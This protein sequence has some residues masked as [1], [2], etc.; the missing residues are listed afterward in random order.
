MPRMESLSPKLDS[1]LDS[2]DLMGCTTLLSDPLPPAPSFSGLNEACYDGAEAN[3][4][5]LCNCKYQNKVTCGCKFINKVRIASHRATHSIQITSASFAYFFYAWRSLRVRRWF[6]DSAWKWK[7]RG[8]P[9]A[10]WESTTR[11]NDRSFEAIVK[12]RA[13]RRVVFVSMSMFPDKRLTTC[14]K[15]ERKDG[16]KRAIASAGECCLPSGFSAG[17]GAVFFSSCWQCG[18]TT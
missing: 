13:T 14:L 3:S 2:E 4:S 16:K 11:G 17:R 12:L 7:F 10:G 18:L 1:P 9:A 8:K 5:N 6:L 15:I